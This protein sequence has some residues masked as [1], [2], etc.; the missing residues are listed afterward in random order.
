ML[1]FF[2]EPYPGELWY[3]V[4]CRYYVRS[5]FPKQAT[6]SEE[7]YQSSAIVHGGLASTLPCI[8]VLNNLPTG[9]LD[10]EE[11]VVNHTLTPYYLRM[12]SLEKK[13]SYYEAVRCKINLWPKNIDPLGPD[14]REGLKFCPVCAK[15]DETRYG[16]PYWHREHQIPLMPLCP[17]H[18]CRLEY[19]GHAWKDIRRNF[20]PLCAVRIGSPD[21]HYLDWE[22]SLSKILDEF[23]K[24][25]V[26]VGPTDGY[27]N[28]NDALVTKGYPVKI[29]KQKPSLI[30]ERLRGLCLPFFGEDIADRFLKPASFAS[31][32]AKLKSWYFSAPEF[33][34]LLAVF[35]GVTASELFGPQM[36]SDVDLVRE[37]YTENISVL[38][39]SSMKRRL[40]TVA[41]EAGLPVSICARNILADALERKN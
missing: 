11:V 3:S 19:G 12:A 13:R 4:L 16:E 18:R 21:Y 14:G 41:G 35:A 26:E 37:R 2:P 39:T 22:L 28:L 34:A 32:T 8:A 23:V 15:E 24:L 17:R 31:L 7:L 29:Y 38:V 6:I 25:P 36:Y 27:S 30:G 40:E 1:N 10:L 20:Y 5:G 33:Y 9:L